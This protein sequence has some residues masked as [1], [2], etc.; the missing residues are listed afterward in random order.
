MEIVTNEKVRMHLQ[1]I[2]KTRSFADSI[3]LTRFLTFIVNETLEGRSHELKEYTI[4]VNALKKD[5]DFNPQI[6]SIVRIHAGRLR[7]ALKEYYYERADKDEVQIVVPKGSY[8]PTFTERSLTHG[9]PPAQGA[10]RYLT[11]SGN[12]EGVA[13]PTLAVLEFDDISEHK[14]HGSFVRGLDIYLSTCFTA[15]RALSVV[16][17]FSSHHIAEKLKDIREAGVLL[18][19][20][21][22]L[23]G[24]VQFDKHLRIHILL[25]FCETGAQLWGTTIE[26]KDAETIDLFQLQ[27]EIVSQVVPSVSD[28]MAGCCC[29]ETPGVEGENKKEAME[30]SYFGLQAF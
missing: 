14:T 30:R 22:I 4:A 2:L 16:S 29:A 17:S 13:R 23:T 21:F 28:V 12:D 5:P 24:C 19:A 1:R 9:I 3:V 8:I 18:K 20:S 26:K 25:N 11:W 10:S 7:R 27:E 15:N 6:D